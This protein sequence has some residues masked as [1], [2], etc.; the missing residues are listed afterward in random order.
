[1]TSNPIPEEVVERAIDVLRDA[2]F[3]PGAVECDDLD[4]AVDDALR[5]VRA[6]IAAMPPRS[7]GQLTDLEEAGEHWRTFKALWLK[8]R[9]AWPTD[10]IDA[11]QA[12]NRL[13]PNSCGKREIQRDTIADVRSQA[14]NAGWDAGI[15]DAAKCARDYASKAR[16]RGWPTAPESAAMAADH[17]AQAIRSLGNSHDRN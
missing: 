6:A 7:T 11:M 8:H 4:D 17:I 5:T 13:L 16:Q 1:M 10:G 2:H 12:L 3:N 9:G 15:E 14:F